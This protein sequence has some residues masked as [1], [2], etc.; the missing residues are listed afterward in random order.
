MIKPVLEDTAVP[1]NVVSGGLKIE[2]AGAV[3]NGTFGKVNE[4]TIT[5]EPLDLVSIDAEA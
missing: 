5:G 4:Y 2:F 3:D 1:R